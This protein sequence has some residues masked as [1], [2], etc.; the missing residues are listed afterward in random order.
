MLANAGDTHLGGRFGHID[1]L[2]QQYKKKM[3]TDVLTNICAMGKLTRE[4][5]KTKGTLSSQQ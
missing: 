2:V 4:A 1:Y 5:E 3:G